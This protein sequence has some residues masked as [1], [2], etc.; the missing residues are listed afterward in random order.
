VCLGAEFNEFCA[1]VGDVLGE[2]RKS[3]F[4]ASV[5]AFDTGVEALGVGV[6]RINSSALGLVEW[7]HDVRDDFSKLLYLLCVE[8]FHVGNCITLSWNANY[9]SAG[10]HF[11]KASPSLR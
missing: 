10:L 7:Q 8:S 4:D 2:S 5:D 1:Q 9:A 6:K 11:S 3:A